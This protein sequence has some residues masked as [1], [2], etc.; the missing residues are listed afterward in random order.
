MTE[1][2]KYRMITTSVLANRYNMNGSLARAVLRHLLQKNLIKP[3][4]L[5]SSN[6]IYTCS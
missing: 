3:V 6:C 5:H 4:A 1:V 2:P